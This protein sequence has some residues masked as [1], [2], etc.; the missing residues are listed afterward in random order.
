[1]SRVVIQNLIKRYGETLA[2]NDVS[3]DVAEGEFLT[4]L[5]SSGCG[6]TTT[7]RCVA[8]LEMPDGGE[9]YFDSRPISRVP[10]FERS[11]GMVFQNY[12]LFPHM[13]V[14]ENLAYGL[15]AE[16]YRDAGFFAR[17][18]IL[19]GTVLANIAADDHKRIMEALEMVE[20]KGFEKRKPGQLSGGQQQ[21]VALARAL[22][23][24]PRVLL[25]DEPL[26]ALDAQLRVKMREEIRRIQKR[27]AITTLYVTHDQEEALAISDRIAVMR[28]G[29][30]AQLGTPEDI[31]KRPRSRFIADFI[32]LG[33]I[34]EARRGDNQRV[35]V[36]GSLEM[37]VATTLPET[38]KFNVAVRPEAIRFLAAGQDAPNTYDGVVTLRMFMGT[39][40]K[41]VVRCDSLEFV[42]MQPEQS[43]SG[44]AMDQPV[45]FSFN[46]DDILVMEAD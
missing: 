33:N 11:C 32:G 36:G 17:T 40:V 18:G 8:G 37:A 31:Y 24:R 15:M 28:H 10:P 26:G 34:F 39:S 42:V 1:M 27:A 4:M 3:L 9:I 21:R 12:A 14:A 2:V 19:F 38:G 6:K 35:S 20:L 41:Y 22:I 29:V 16:R 46:P 13:T 43:D 25:F 45:R 23:T 44:I 30:I 5:G 7:L